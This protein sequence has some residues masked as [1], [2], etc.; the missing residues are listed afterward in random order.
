MEFS[1]WLAFF[2]ASWAISLS[3]GAG[4]IAAMAPAPG[5]RLMAH[6]A[7]KKPSQT[8]NSMMRLLQDPSL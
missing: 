1:V 5:D 6:E 8:E 4:A 7:A 3:P 2:A